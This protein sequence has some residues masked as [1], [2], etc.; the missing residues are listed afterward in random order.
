MQYYEM[1]SRGL[2]ENIV[3]ENVFASKSAR[4]LVKFPRVFSYRMFGIVD[5]DGLADFKNIKISNL[6]RDETHDPTAPTFKIAETVT[7]DNLI[8]D[9]VVM[10]NC[11]N[12]DK[13]PVAVNVDRIKNLSVNHLMLENEP[14]DFNL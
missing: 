3:I 14:V 9:N 5:F 10:N 13:M 12:D 6:Y 11:V 2:F 1:N 7:I 8:I 4:A